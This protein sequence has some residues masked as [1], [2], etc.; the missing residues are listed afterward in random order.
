VFAVFAVARPLHELLWLL[1]EALAVAPALTDALRAAV[2]STEALVAGP[3]AGLV[4]LDVEAHRA[5]VL[6]LLREASALARAGTSGRD[7]A[8]ADL[9]G[10]R[11]GGA[12]LRGA[13]LRGALL[14]GADLRRADLRLADVTGADLRA[15]DVRGSDL[16]RTL[17]LSQ[18]QADAA[19]GDDTTLLPESLDRPRHWAGTARSA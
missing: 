11:L 7:L 16:T 2:A 14:L 4:D 18:Q 8:G 1:T 6:P 3:P 5:A 9:A 10:A 15:A 12:D 19:R 13:S 17:F